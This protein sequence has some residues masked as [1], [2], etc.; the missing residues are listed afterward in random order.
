[1]KYKVIALSVA[2]SNNRVLKSGDIVTEEHFFPGHAQKL[3][4]SGHIA[5]HEEDVTP[6]GMPYELTV[7]DLLRNPSL[8]EEGLKVGETIY[9][10]TEEFVSKD[11]ATEQEF[12]DSL[13]STY[14]TLLPELVEAI[15]AK[16]T[17][18]TP[19][20]EDLSAG[21]EK[22]EDVLNPFY[23]DKVTPFEDVLTPVVTPV[24]PTVED[25]GTG[26]E[27][28]NTGRKPKS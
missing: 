8:L 25:Q 15:K 3:V 27:K 19:A 23:S 2:G 10:P 14:E 26:E 20:A 1:M 17:P 28:K 16:V 5:P 6:T 4:E 9:L 24:T 11:D 7:S 13:V 12:S 22:K 21:N 18:V